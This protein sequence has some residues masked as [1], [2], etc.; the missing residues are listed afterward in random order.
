MG[1]WSMQEWGDGLCK[2]GV[3]VSA[4]EEWGYGLCKSGVMVLQEWDDGFARVG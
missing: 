2:S 3:I 1:R 4:R